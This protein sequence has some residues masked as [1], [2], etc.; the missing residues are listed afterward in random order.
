[1]KF[2]T[3]INI[4][5][6]IDNEIT[7]SELSRR[8]KMCYPNIIVLVNKI[9]NCGFIETTKSGRDRYIKLTKKGEEVKK[10]VYKYLLQ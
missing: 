4:F 9:E 3:F 5:S 2:K 10:L 8:T 7:I 6:N 1:M